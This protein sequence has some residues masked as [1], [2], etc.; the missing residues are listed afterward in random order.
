MNRFYYRP[1]LL[2]AVFFCAFSLLS[3]CGEDKTSST[4]SVQFVTTIPP[5]QTILAPVVGPS[6]PAAPLLS[7]GASPHTYEPRPSDLRRLSN[8]QALFYGA[9][10]LD[11]WAAEL[12]APAHISLL[13]LLPDSSLRPLPTWEGSS[14]DP[15]ARTDPHFWTDPLTVQALLPAL[16]DTL[17]TLVPQNCPQYQANASVFKQQLSALDQK[18]RQQLQPYANTKVILAAPFFQ[19]FM[20]RYQLNLVGVIEPAP[21]KEASPRAL[22]QLIHQAQKQK[23][24][25]IFTLPQL[26]S[27][28]ARVV[29]ETANIPIYELDPLGGTSGQNSYEEL[30]MYNVHIIQKAL[31]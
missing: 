10:S 8:S 20:E 9:E 14:T 29:S 15:T 3:G 21:G 12:P 26:P 13:S 4:A 24:Q 23:A 19:Y 7:A 31:Q 18:I 6:S 11:G 1:C 30:L 22:Q 17:C 25:V 28:A 27:R 5:F 2:L 16:T